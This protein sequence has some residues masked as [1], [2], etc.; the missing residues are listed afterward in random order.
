MLT[1]PMNAPSF[2]ILVLIICYMHNA[3]SGHYKPVS[4]A[5]EDRQHIKKIGNLY[6]PVS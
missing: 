4:T 2:Q 5:K 1:Y 6:F 3:L